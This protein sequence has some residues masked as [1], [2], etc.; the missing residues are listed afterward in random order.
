MIIRISSRRV[1]S[2]WFDQLSRCKMKG[3]HLVF[4][5]RRRFLK[6]SQCSFVHFKGNLNFPIE[7]IKKD[8]KL[9]IIAFYKHQLK[10]NLLTYNKKIN[11]LKA[12]KLACHTANLS[13]W[14]ALFKFFGSHSTLPRWICLL[15][16]IYNQNYAFK[17]AII[18]CLKLWF[19]NYWRGVKKYNTTV[20]TFHN[21]ALEERKSQIIRYW[22]Q[23]AEKTFLKAK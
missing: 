11:S 21:E 2:I 23:H 5:H 1:D 9:G 22:C 17:D 6:I 20:E 10:K 4:A 14:I 15:S 19:W 3:S 13:F 7:P 12:N 18:F 8:E 16:H